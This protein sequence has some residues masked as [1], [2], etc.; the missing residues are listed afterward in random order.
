MLAGTGETDQR[1]EV[2]RVDR[3]RSQKPALR[4]GRQLGAHLAPERARRLGENHR[5]RRALSLR[6]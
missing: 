4:L 3:Q 2:L 1:F 6:R 5:R